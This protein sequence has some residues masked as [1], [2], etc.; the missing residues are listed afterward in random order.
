M[1][2][3]GPGSRP[4]PVPHQFPPGADWGWGCKNS[5]GPALSCTD[6]RDGGRGAALV[7]IRALYTEAA[8]ESQQ[9]TLSFQPVLLPCG[10]PPPASSPPAL[11]SLLRPQA[12]PRQRRGAGRAGGGK[13]RPKGYG[14]GVEAGTTEADKPVFLEPKARVLSPSPAPPVE[15]D[16]PAK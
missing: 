2:R 3:L 10:C 13:G 6:F 7:L 1:R 11:A 4:S 5:G 15:L 9:G 12:A 14:G 16:L 8:A